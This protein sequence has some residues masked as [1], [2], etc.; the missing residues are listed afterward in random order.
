M[1]QT[2]VRYTGSKGNHQIDSLLVSLSSSL[3]HSVHVC[4]FRFASVVVFWSSKVIARRARREGGRGS[5]ANGPV[6][7]GAEGLARRA[8]GGH[9][10][11]KRIVPTPAGCGVWS[12]PPHGWARAPLGSV[13]FV[14]P[15][16]GPA[17]ACARSPLG[18]RF[19]GCQ[20]RPQVRPRRAGSGRRGRKRI[21]KHGISNII[22]GLVFASRFVALRS[23]VFIWLR[24]CEWG[25]G[26]RAG[27]HRS[28]RARAVMARDVL[29]LSMAR[30]PLR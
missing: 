24:R 8:G 5:R 9:R 20:N 29:L 11:R 25:V 14:C 17:R 4:G 19:L 27:L 23:C 3:L 26:F 18:G 7:P 1:R 30:R 21:V 22:G 10:G 15:P 28:I 6:K 12:C 13:Q 16:G 2:R